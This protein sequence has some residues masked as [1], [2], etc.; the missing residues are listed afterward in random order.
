MKSAQ[1]LFKELSKFVTAHTVHVSGTGE[2]FLA[3]VARKHHGN[4][5][6]TEDA[7]AK[8]SRNFALRDRKTLRDLEDIF[9]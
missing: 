9:S 6:A 8:I 1:T 3:D 4:K 7:I 5:I 2:K